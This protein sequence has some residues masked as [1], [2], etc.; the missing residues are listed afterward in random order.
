[1]TKAYKVALVKTKEVRMIEVL[2]WV[3]KHNSINRFYDKYS[4]VK[5]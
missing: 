2:V 3:T 1:M 5:Y 4:L